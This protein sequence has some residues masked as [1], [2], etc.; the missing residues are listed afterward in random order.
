MQSAIEGGVPRPAGAHILR[1]IANFTS[2]VLHFYREHAKQL[3]NLHHYVADQVDKREFTLAELALEGLGLNEENLN[4]VSLF[5]VDWASRRHKFLIEKDQGSLFTDHYV[6]QPKRMASILETV[7]NW[8]HEHQGYHVRAA[9]GMPSSDLRSHPLQQ[10][11][12]KAKKLIHISRKYRSPTVMGSVGPTSG[13]EG[14]ECKVQANDTFSETDQVILEF[15]LHYSITP[16]QMTSATLRSTGSHIMRATGM[17]DTM[18]VNASTMPL[19]LQELGVVSPWENLRLLDQNLALPGH[20]VSIHADNAWDEVQKECERVET[21][22]TDSM[23]DMRRD[24]GD[25]LVYCVDNPGAQEID[26]GVSLERAGDDTYWVRV[27]VA[28]PSAFLE[29]DG[30]IAKYAAS[31]LQSLYVPERTYPMLPKGFTHKHFSLAAGRP[32]LTFSAKMN[33]QGDILDTEITNGTVHNVI[34]TTHDMLTEFFEPGLNLR[35]QPLQV[36]K[37]IQQPQDSP[38]TLSDDDKNTFRTL[39]Q[40]LLAFRDHRRRNGAIDFPYSD[41]TSLTVD[42]GS[43]LEP[44]KMQVKQSHFHLSD[45]SISLGVSTK[46]PHEV[47]DLTKRYLISTIMNLAGYVAG[48]WC[49]DRSIPAVYDGTWFHPE[50][51]QLTSENIAQSGGDAW[52]KLAAPR[53]FSSP[54]PIH[55]SPLGLDYYVKCTSPL[56]RY[57]DL[58]AHFQIEAALRHEH[59]TRTPL[60]TSTISSTLPFSHKDI[61]SFI[62]RSLWKSL[63]LRDCSRASYQFWACLLLFRAF[64]FDDSPTSLPD[65]FPVL[66]EK[67]Y[68][69]T[70]LLGTEFQD[71]FLGVISSLGVRCQVVVGEEF[72]AENRLHVGTLVDAR[73]TEVNMARQIVVMELVGVVKPFERVGEWA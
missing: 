63:A 62:S 13:C 5:A 34:Y 26:D 19:F 24:W 66:L 69:L 55:H 6:A 56:R 17:Y 23:K 57:I 15:L 54:T 36:G 12:Q 68:S 41:N 59:S 2:E 37:K 35:S 61:E 72:Q 39:R 29:H 1:E 3:D 43:T 50:Y 10:F 32:S 49:A 67:P 27:H 25:L 20:G 33:L 16:R 42:H 48:K 45:P 52:R 51:T 64:Y 38:E 40:L 28:N 47:P 65:T 44:Y 73:I 31:R 18:E 71:G 8:V 11:I 46:D 30:L 60:T 21:N 22:L 7:T 58:L 70:A 9:M 53:G 14:D 4:E